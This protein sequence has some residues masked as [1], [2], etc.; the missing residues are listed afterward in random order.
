MI[1]LVRHWRQR[2]WQSISAAEY[3]G[4][5][6]RFGGSFAVHPRVVATIESLRGLPVR[7]LGYERDGDWLAALP[8]WG[9]HVVGTKAALKRYQAR[10]LIDT[11]DAEVILP[12][13]DHARV[14][15]PFRADFLSALHADHIVNLRRESRFSLMLAKSHA[16]G[17]QSFSKKFRYN[18]QRE[19]RLF[20][21]AGGSHRSVA[22]LPPAEVAAAYARLFEKRWG[23]PAP[24]LRTCGRTTRRTRRRSSERRWC[25]TSPRRPRT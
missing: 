18:R 17:D 14:S 6:A 15:L 2:H 7:Y 21:E 4:V 19:L 8:V 11:G 24:A 9:H 22:D 13:A 5:Y 16:R 23:F 1:S 25:R 10:H 12:I 20:E 3:A